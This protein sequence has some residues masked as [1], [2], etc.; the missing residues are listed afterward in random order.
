MQRWKKRQGYYKSNKSAMRSV[1]L[2]QYD[3]AMQAKLQVT[4]DWEANK[5]DLLFVL[6]AAKLTRISMQESYSMNVVAR[7]AFCSLA[8]CFQNSDPAL[9]FKQKYLATMKKMDK[10]GTAFKFAKKFLVSEKKK[11]SKLDNAA[12]TKAAKSCFL[13]TMWLMNS[14]VPHSMTDNLVQAH[15]SENDNYLKSVV[16]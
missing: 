6:K 1:V 12:A 2:G 16:C 15:I 3:M 7:E 8:N 11:N 10:A 4:E 14:D 9:I 13:G 5:T